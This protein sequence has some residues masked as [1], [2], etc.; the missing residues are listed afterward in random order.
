MRPRNAGRNVP[1]AY[2][3]KLTS[4][5]ETMIHQKVGTQRSRQMGRTLRTNQ[6]GAGSESPRLAEPD[7]LSAAPRCGSRRNRTSG[8]ITNAGMAATIMALRQP[9]A[10][11][12]GP[13]KK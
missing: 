8:A 12:T 11:A 13:L 3:L 2:R 1:I 4:A 6:D 10:W 7:A 5:P 9:K